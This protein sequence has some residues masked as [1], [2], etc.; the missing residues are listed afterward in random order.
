MTD[1]PASLS[2][3]GAVEEEPHKYLTLQ[4][5]ERTGIVSADCSCGK[6]HEETDRAAYASG[7]M[8]Y[9]DQLVHDWALRHRK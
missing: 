3:P 1:H 6:W 7:A 4:V 5:D 8:F 2:E 9:T